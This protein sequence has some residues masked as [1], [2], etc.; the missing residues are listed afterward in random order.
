MPDPVSAIVS[1]GSSLLSSS[2]Q[3]DAASDAAAIQAGASEQGIAEQRRQF[4]EVRRLL[5]PYVQT[6][7]PALRGMQNII[8][9][10][11]A[12]A[13]REAIAEIEQGP[14]LQALMRQGEDAILQQA[15]ATGGLR[16]GNLQGALAQFRPSMLQQ[17]IDQQYARL[18]GL[19]TLGQQSAAGVGSAGMQTGANVSGLIQQGGAAQAG[20]VLGRGAAFSQLAQVPGQLAGF[21][22]ATGRSIFGGTPIQPGIVSGLPAWAVMEG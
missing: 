19:T 9:L 15:S 5:A 4:D 2:M 8:G 21:Q 7:Q 22:L 18:G 6:G 11:G 20:G 13:Q 17:A 3:S 16:G 12:Q 1:A 14:L 10:G